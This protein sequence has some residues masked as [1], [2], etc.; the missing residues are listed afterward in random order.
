MSHIALFNIPGHGHVN[1]TLAIVAELVRRGHRVSYVITEEFAPQVEAAGATA[2]VY[3][4]T[5]PPTHRSQ[6]WPNDDIV[7]MSSLFLEEAVTVLPA[8]EKAFEDDGPDLVLYDF[9]AHTARMLA[10]RWGVPA[11]RLSPTH[12]PSEGY[13]EHREVM[14]ELMAENRAWVHYRRRFRDFLDRGG[15]T[16][17]VNDYTD[18]PE[19]CVVTLP[20]QFQFRGET[21]DDRY[22]FVGPCITE[23]P[24]QGSWRA[25]DDGRPVLLISLGSVLSDTAF[26]QQ[27]FEAFGGLDWH[28]VMV[29]GG[30]TDPADLGTPPPNFEVHRRVPQLDVLARAD[31]FVTHAGMGSVMEAVH[32]GVPMVAVPKSADQP[33]NA[34]SIARL[35]LGSFLPPEDV[36]ADALRAAVLALAADRELPGRMARMQ[37]QVRAAG[38]PA[39]V[40][41]MVEQRLASRG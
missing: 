5:L 33:M 15:V 36:D 37:E 16:M 10:Q 18:E 9:T 12:V 32:H 6:D 20:R 4:S 39:T 30:Q 28:V 34:Q 14:Q 24:L 1:P 7:A 26:Y 27:C 17:S 25:P 40:A 13:V 2:V 41:D 19:R 8:Q 35:G 29:V 22:V 21:V 11:I 38:G 3:D 31:A 23:R